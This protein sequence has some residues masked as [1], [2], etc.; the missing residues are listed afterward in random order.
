MPRPRSRRSRSPRRAS[1]AR[2]SRSPRRASA[3]RRSRSNHERTQRYRSTHIND[4][5]TRYRNKQSRSALVQTDVGHFETDTVLKGIV[6]IYKYSDAEKYERIIK[7]ILTNHNEDGYPE[8]SIIHELRGSVYKGDIDRFSEILIDKLKKLLPERESYIYSVKTREIQPQEDG[9]LHVLEVSHQD[10]P[11]ADGDMVWLF[12]N[13]GGIIAVDLDDKYENQKLSLLK[14]HAYIHYVLT[15]LDEN[16]GPI[17]INSND[18]TLTLHIRSNERT[19]ETEISSQ[20]RGVLIA[21]QFD[22]IKKLQLTTTRKGKGKPLSEIK[23]EVE[24]KIQTLKDQKAFNE[25]QGKETY[26]HESQIEQLKKRLKN[27]GY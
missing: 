24:Q 1:A 13:I 11:R 15:F 12:K 21:E 10:D 16:G 26:I 9:P 4:F 3:A 23:K 5:E 22:E 25:T 19:G 17:A 6:N 27:M 18:K 14:G 20:S 7:S 2:R 8:N